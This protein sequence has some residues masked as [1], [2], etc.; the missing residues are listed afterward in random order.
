[1]CAGNPA[2][3]PD[4][5]RALQ[6]AERLRRPPLLLR[7]HASS[8]VAANTGNP[9]LMTSSVQRLTGGQLELR[10]YNPTG[11]PQPLALQ[12]PN[13]QVVRADGQARASLPGVV[14]PHQIITLRQRSVA[15]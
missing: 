5:T 8:T 9:V 13:W 15:T 7:G 3:D 10:L 1:L 12:E 11:Q 6:A 2:T 4:Q 14:Q